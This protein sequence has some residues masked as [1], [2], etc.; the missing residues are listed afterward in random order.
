MRLFFEKKQ[1]VTHKMYPNPFFSWVEELVWV[2]VVE[3]NRFHFVGIR[4][5]IVSRNKRDYL[6]FTLYPRDP[7]TMG[8][9]R[10]IVTIK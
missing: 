1:E 8:D 3:C 2:G 6:Y 4:Y 7:S 9:H 5:S 10:E